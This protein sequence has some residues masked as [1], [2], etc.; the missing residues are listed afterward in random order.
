[1]NVLLCFIRYTRNWMHSQVRWDY[2]I[3]LQDPDT[4]CI[5]HLISGSWTTVRTLHLMVHVLVLHDALTMIELSLNATAVGTQVC[6]LHQSRIFKIFSAALY[7]LL[8]KPYLVKS[9]VCWSVKCL[10]AIFTAPLDDL[11]GPKSPAKLV[12]FYIYHSVRHLR[13]SA[14]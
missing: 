8:V 14:S 7:I 13:K 10:A 5:L 9:K 4:R 11:T 2:L 12:G 6:T 3:F 1:V